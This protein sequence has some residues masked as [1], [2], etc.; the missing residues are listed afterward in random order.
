MAAMPVDFNK[1]AAITQ[2]VDNISSCI[3]QGPL[4]V[5]LNRKQVGT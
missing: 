5:E 1:I 3:Q 4:L 2:I